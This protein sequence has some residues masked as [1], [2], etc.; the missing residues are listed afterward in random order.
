VYIEVRYKEFM[1]DIESGKKMIDGDAFFN[2][3]RSKY[4]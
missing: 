1:E 3:M 2:K 4:E